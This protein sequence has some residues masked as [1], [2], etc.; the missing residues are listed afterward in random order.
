MGDIRY[1]P[2]KCPECKGTYYICDASSSLMYVDICDHCG[3]RNSD[4]EY[5]EI[6]EDEIILCTKK[7]LE[8]LMKKEPKVQE[9]RERIEKL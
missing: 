2:K 5:Y 3:S 4:L 8:R 1:I 7:K 9:F 6:G